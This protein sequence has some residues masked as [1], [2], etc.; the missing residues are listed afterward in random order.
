[1]VNA[2]GLPSHWQTLLTCTSIIP[3]DADALLVTIAISL[4]LPTMSTSNLQAIFQHLSEAA[5]KEYER[6]TILTHPL[7]HDLRYCDS[8]S[9]FL[10]ILHDQF[11]DYKQSTKKDEILAAIWFLPV[12]IILDHPCLGCSDMEPTQAITNADAS[13]GLME[14]FDGIG[15]FVIR[16]ESYIEAPPM[17]DAVKAIIVKIMTEVIG[18]LGLVTKEVRQSRT[19]ESITDVTFPVAD[20]GLEKILKTLIGK[21]DI[22]DA[23]R[24]WDRLMEEEARV[25]AA[26]AYVTR[27]VGTRVETVSNQ[28]THANDLV[29]E[30]A[31]STLATYTCHCKP[32]YD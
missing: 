16:L 29:H 7:R 25:L 32:L 2:S 19:S 1:M 28:V 23:L 26:Q 6:K 3:P 31:F 20:K 5:L 30:G 15:N 8:P 27:N 4:T 13:Q 17:T 22:E 9:S 24:R 12:V 10:A 14:I 21:T 18:F 11:Q